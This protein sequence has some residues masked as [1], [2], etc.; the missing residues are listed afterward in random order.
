MVKNDIQYDVR[1]KLLEAGKTQKEIA[2]E[3]GTTQ[4]YVSAFGKKVD[5]AVNRTLVKIMDA[6]GYDIVLTYVKKDGI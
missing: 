3:I 2:E 1:R 5:G 4:T 6:L